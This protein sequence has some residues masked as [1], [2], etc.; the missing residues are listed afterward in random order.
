[1]KSTTITD[2]QAIQLFNSGQSSALEI[3]IERYKERIFSSIYML[4]K[5]KYT[6]EDIFQD[7]FIKIIENL[8]AGNYKEES[9]F[10]QWAMRIA[11]NLCID[12]FRKTK[13]KPVIRTSEGNDIFDVLQFDE[14][15]A[16]EKVMKNQSYSLV[17]KMV[18]LLPQE[19][20]EVII[21]RHFANLKFKQISELLNCS[22]NTALG[23]MRY[24]LLNI[25]KMVEENHVTL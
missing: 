10:L 7:L 16:E 20:Q 12:H 17:M 21:L 24:G 18:A 14:M 19:Q 23:R 5:D 3:L 11:H 4:V 15:N 22:V 13:N 8:Q 1:M 2:Q 9:K 25:R 6:A